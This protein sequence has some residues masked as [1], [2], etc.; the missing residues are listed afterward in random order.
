MNENKTMIITSDDE[1]LRYLVE[2]GTDAIQMKDAVGDEIDVA[3]IFQYPVEKEGVVSTC[4]SLVS[5]DGLV[6]QTLSPTVDDCVKSIWR[7]WGER[8]RSIN[9]RV[10]FSEGSSNNNRKFLNLRVVSWSV[11]E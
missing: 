5:N 1:L 3:E 11:I 4:T 10:K 6:Y 9:I 2:T 7:I 8:W